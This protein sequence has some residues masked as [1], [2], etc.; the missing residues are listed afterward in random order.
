MNTNTVTFESVGSITIHRTL[1]RLFDN[2]NRDQSRYLAWI[3]KTP[4]A[5]SAMYLYC[6]IHVNGNSAYPAKY[7]LPCVAYSVKGEVANVLFSVYDL[8]EAYKMCPPSNANADQTRYKQAQIRVRRRRQ[9]R[10][11]SS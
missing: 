7:K 3:E 10:R 11:S 4:F 5:V 2:K 6:A 8:V 9:R 1:G